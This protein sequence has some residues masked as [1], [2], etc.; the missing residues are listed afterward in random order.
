LNYLE[1]LGI[2]EHVVTWKQWHDQILEE[3]ERK[4]EDDESIK[5]LEEMLHSFHFL[6][7]KEAYIS[8][9]YVFKKSR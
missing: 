7:N 5:N 6:E 8:L 1:G 3:L 2:K 4:D 9:L